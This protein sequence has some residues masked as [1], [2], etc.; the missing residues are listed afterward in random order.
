[1]QWNCLEAAKDR[2]ISFGWLFSMKTTLKLGFYFLSSIVAATCGAQTAQTVTAPVPVP[3][4]YK[5]VHSDENSD[6]LQQTF[7]QTT[8]NGKAVPHVRLVTRIATGLNYWD[9]SEW[10]PSDP[11]FQI[12]PDGQ[13][14]YGNKVQTQVQLLANLAASNSVV[15]TTPDGIVLS[16]TPV[17]IVL[18]NAVSGNSTIIASITNC[19][20]TLISSNQV[21][22]ENAFAGDGISGDILYT[23]QRGSFSQDIVWKQN[24]NPADYNFPTNSTQIQIFSAFNSP[25]PQ[26]T[27][28][29]LYVET[30][31]AVRAQ[32]AS[33]DFIDHTLKF[34]Q[35]KFGPGRAFSTTATNSFAGAPIAKD[36]ETINGQSY[37][38]ES[39]E[40]SDIQ[41]Q[42][43]S[44]TTNATVPR[45]S[46]LKRQSRPA[47]RDKEAAARAKGMQFL[48]LPLP[49]SITKARFAINLGKKR[50]ADVMKAKSVISDYIAVPATGPDPMV[51][52]S[53]QTFFVDGPADFDD[54]VLEGGCVIKYPN[55][56]GAYIEVDGNLTCQ[57]QP[58]L[59]TIFTAADD[60]SVGQSMSGVW[61][62]YTGTIQPGGYAVAALY[63]P[64]NSAALSNL[65]ILHA[66]TGI[67]GYGDMMV[68]NLQIMNCGY[69]FY[70]ASQNNSLF[71]N[72]LIANVNCAFG[73]NY[74][75]EAT[76]ENA[77]V[78]NCNL[79][80]G[81]NNDAEV[82]LYFY[83]SILANVTNLLTDDNGDFVTGNNN[84]FY[85][86]DNTGFGAQN[87]DGI[88]TNIWP[89][90]VVGAGSYY[91]A[92]NCVFHC[93]G[94]TNI[95]PAL[96]ADLAQRTTWPP[97]V[98][99]EQD[100]SSTLTLG[101]SISR[102]TNSSPD[103][104][105]HYDAL[106][107]VFA[108]CSVSANLT[109]TNGVAIGFF[110]DSGPFW[111]PN[112]IA[113]NDGANVSFNGN[114]TQPCRFALYSLVQEGNGNWTA[115]ENGGFEGAIVF[116][117]SSTIPQVSANFTKCGALPQHQLLNDN[118]ASGGAK[119]RNCEF[120][121]GS[122]S[123]YGSE[124]ANFTNCLF[125][126]PCI[127]FWDNNYPISYAFE[128]CTFY[129]GCLYSSRTGG[130]SSSFWLIENCS[131]DGT[132]FD[133][134]DDLNGNFTN[135][136][137][138]FN[139]YNTNN[140]GWITYQGGFSS[141]NGT[142]E[143]V[144]PNDLMTTN[145][146]WETSWF[147][148]FYL[149]TNSP[150][151]AN[152]STTADQ[153]GLFEF[154]TQTN[155]VPEGTNFVDI[156][157]HYV[158]TDTNGNP[159]DTYVPGTPN[160]IV[161]SGGNGIDTNGLAYWW[162]AQYF[163][164]IGLNPFTDPDGDGYT[165][166]YAYTNGISPN[167]LT[168]IRPILLGSWSFDN[169]NTWIGNQGQLP[170]GAYNLVGVP[171]WE[172]NAVLVDATSAA[173]LAYGN[174][175]PGGEANFNLRNGTL[176]FWFLP[177][178]ASANAGGVGPQTEGRFL[179]IGSPGTASG[180]WGLLVDSAGTNI[181]FC[182]ET[183][184]IGSLTTN[185]IAP[186]S[187]PSNAWHQ[188][189]LTYSSTN[190]SLFIDGQPVTTNGLGISYYPNL[191]AQANGFAIG[192]SWS[193][194]SNADGTFEELTTYNYPL[195]PYAIDANG[196]GMS[197]IWEMDYFGTL[198][199][200][201]YTDLSNDG[202]S[203][204]EKSEFDVNPAVPYPA[205]PASFSV[206][207]CPQ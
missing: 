27:A 82:G 181:Y 75:T 6:I 38:I 196:D 98:Y 127:T 29:P 25:A 201:P 125:L 65:R 18:Y 187:W 115:G 86:C 136:L 78:A 52:Q 135:T 54:V 121:N 105:Y 40:Y 182:T 58:Y 91:L 160:Y 152:G 2:T 92:T 157:Y 133:W 194:T 110:G 50:L 9:G 73:G 49:N 100:I 185:L 95:D 158:A 171:S 112:S 197:D 43:Q 85:N 20:G 30:N 118:W 150:L 176:S 206:Q 114:A 1:M 47:E 202:L 156:G 161:D 76:A 143:V 184:S 177:N 37:L 46:K 16:T 172:T 48:A 64:G 31:Q 163:G 97:N 55:I 67:Y 169:T 23:L 126:R 94:T 59:P 191:A 32:M 153:V 4:P 178:W 120:Y 123:T 175:Q 22:F 200:N 124:Y 19:S 144:G 130:D 198:N 141:N 11:T 199:V 128:N 145:Y 35:L 15:I 103:L 116:N 68:T 166:F 10:S 195:T 26:E 162:E 99:D 87:L 146:N 53:D 149:P 89:F 132:A 74:L 62:N 17:A 154:T 138:N 173:F 168:T 93:A 71:E 83:N 3:T 111:A 39:V 45:T 151:L 183:N 188:I 192:S 179:E 70:I 42:L 167:D 148:N 51:F 164:Q 34:G 69:G 8:P 41:S 61:T 190:S 129:D 7:Y 101:P 174:L 113:L 186:I 57:T 107:D 24:I 60:D 90:Q 5:V 108:G 189:V 180:W 66:V 204:L 139:S 142:N 13:Y 63:F 137:F 12:S 14:V 72:L 131:F 119:F 88:T 207:T 77:T 21:Y 79:L 36:F 140:P 56:P 102:D 96:L 106:D 134:N 104:G 33:P 147:G 165:I 117:G 170:T 159:L 81:D 155:Q 205:I 44:L 28:R 84:G 203:N 109:F 193:G 80:L 122:I